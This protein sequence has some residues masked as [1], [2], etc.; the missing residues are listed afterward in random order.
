MMYQEGDDIT[1]VAFLP[2]DLNLINN[3]KSREVQ[4]KNTLQSNWPV[5]FNIDKVIKDGDWG[6]AMDGGN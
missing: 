4:I 1:S 2:N 5:L 3:N 6:T